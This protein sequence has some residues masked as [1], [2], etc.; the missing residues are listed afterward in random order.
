[1]GRVGIVVELGRGVEHT[2]RVAGEDIG[3]EEEDWDIGMVGL[4]FGLGELLVEAVVRT[5]CVRPIM[6]EN[7]LAFR[8]PN[9]LDLNSIVELHSQEQVNIPPVVVVVVKHVVS[10]HHHP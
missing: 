7:V 8:I 2:E 9:S 5:I 3:V 10:D 6:K 1:V 4:V